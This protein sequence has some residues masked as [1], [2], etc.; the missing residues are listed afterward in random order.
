[1]ARQRAERVSDAVREVAAEILHGLKDPRIGFVTVVRAEVSTDLRHAKIFVSVF[2]P[3]AEREATM[4]A[5]ERAKGHVRTELGRRIRLYHTPEVHFIAD[6]SIAHGDRIARLLGQLAA[7]RNAAQR[8]AGVDAD[9]AG[10]DG[11]L[12]VDTPGEGR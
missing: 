7:A 6:S 5:L 1:M 4:A 9:L 12:P 2:G 3:D 11:Q 8:A 10:A